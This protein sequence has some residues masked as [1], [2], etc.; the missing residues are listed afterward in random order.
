MVRNPTNKLR[1]PKK[2]RWE[3]YKKLLRNPKKFVEKSKKLYWEIQKFLQQ[4]QKVSAI[5]LKTVTDKSAK[6]HQQIQKGWGRWGCWSQLI[7]LITC[8]KGSK[9][10]SMLYGSDFQQCGINNARG[11]RGNLLS[12]LGQL[13]NNLQLQCLKKKI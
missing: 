1:N 8:L 6:I 9:S 4:I 13:K 2:T 12:V 11:W 3:I 5:N 7:T 10:L